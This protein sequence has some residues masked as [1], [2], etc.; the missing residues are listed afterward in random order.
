MGG[1]RRKDIRIY[2]AILNVVRSLKEC[3][4]IY[5]RSNL[6]LLSDEYNDN[7]KQIMWLGDTVKMCLTRNRMVSSSNPIAYT[8]SLRNF[9]EQEIYTRLLQVDSA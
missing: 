1:K 7:N 8:W 5:L 3:V 2:E 4:E 6:K 9:C